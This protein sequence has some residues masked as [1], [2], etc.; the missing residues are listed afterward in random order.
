MSTVPLFHSNVTDVMISQLQD[1]YVQGFISRQGVGAD[2]KRFEYLVSCPRD[3]ENHHL[4]MGFEIL[5]ADAKQF[6]CAELSIGETHV[7]QTGTVEPL[8]VDKKCNFR[9][10][11]KRNLNGSSQLWIPMNVHRYFEIQ[12]HIFTSTP[13]EDDTMVLF[14]IQKVSG[15]KST[16]LMSPANSQMTIPDWFVQGVGAHIIFEETGVS[17]RDIHARDPNTIAIYE[18]LKKSYINAKSESDVRNGA[19]AVAAIGGV[20]VALE[21]EVQSLTLCNRTRWQSRMAAQCTDMLQ[22]LNDIWSVR[23]S[24]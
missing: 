15:W 16:D 13:L 2:P 19:A 1:V 17:F 3:L 20:I 12:L 24:Q 8:S 10:G 9:L 7:N 22:L 4:L 6:D 23:P 21:H 18:S 14:H 5:M 11:F